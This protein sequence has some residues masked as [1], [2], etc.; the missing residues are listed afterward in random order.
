MEKTYKIVGETN[1]W[2][3]QRNPFFNG[4]TIK[5]IDCGLSLK[6]ARNLL[7]QYFCKMYD[8]YFPNWGVAMNSQIG[9]DYANHFQDGTYSFEFDSKY[10]RIEIEE[11]EE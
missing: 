9:R 10:Y 5:T 3:A 1:S 8:V 7:L 6:E 4:K 2:I 11:N